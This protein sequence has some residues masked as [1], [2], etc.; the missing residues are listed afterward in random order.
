M[1]LRF[2]LVLVALII[3]GA[4]GYSLLH[5]GTKWTTYHDVAHGWT[6]D[7]PA[8]F[9]VRPGP[10][11]AAFASVHDEGAGGLPDSALSVGLSTSPRKVVARDTPFPLD[12]VALHVPT[13]LVG[14]DLGVLALTFYHRRHAYVLSVDTHDAK[15]WQSTAFRMI[16]SVRF[17]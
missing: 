16:R 6:I 11:G 17:S 10:F 1:S 13:P 12:P 14:K 4:G 9:A 15:H 7:V 2:R 8:S 3:A 5:H